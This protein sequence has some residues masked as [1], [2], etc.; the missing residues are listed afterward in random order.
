MEEENLLHRYNGRLVAY[1]GVSRFRE[2]LGQTTVQ[3]V[4]ARLHARQVLD[5]RVTTAR[6]S[7]P[8]TIV[9]SGDDLDVTA[10][11]ASLE[12]VRARLEETADLRVRWQAV[13]TLT[14]SPKTR[15]RVAG[16]SLWSPAVPRM[17]LD[18]SRAS[19]YIQAHAERRA[20][21][22]STRVADWGFFLE[23]DPERFVAEGRPEA[24][25]RVISTDG[26]I[27]VLREDVPKWAD[28]RTGQ[29]CEANPLILL[30]VDRVFG[31]LLDRAALQNADLRDLFRSWVN[32]F[33]AFTRDNPQLAWDHHA[34]QY[35]PLPE[36]R[37]TRPSPSLIRVLREAGGKDV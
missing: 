2:K 10:F 3:N 34:Q 35:L 20:L 18:V 9:K 19:E 13:V 37:D 25:N 12:G 26:L 27:R 5:Q 1:D 4:N 11:V 32:D 33:V 30:Q 23:E 17:D 15:C 21:A 29:S 8:A 22:G 28:L 6:T 24:A 7:H 31:A 14:T 16:I 36:D